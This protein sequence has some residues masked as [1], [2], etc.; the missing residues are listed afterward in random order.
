MDSTLPLWTALITLNSS[1]LLEAS[2]TP[3]SQLKSFQIKPVPS[4]SN[5]FRFDRSL[6]LKKPVSFQSKCLFFSWLPFKSFVLRC[7]SS[8]LINVFFSF[9][10]LFFS[11]FFKQFFFWIRLFLLW[12]H[13]PPF[14]KTALITLN[15]SFPSRTL[16]WDSSGSIKVFL[17]I[18]RPFLIKLLSDITLPFEKGSV[19]FSIKTLV[20]TRW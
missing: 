7:K 4:Q 3:P 18:A 13:S 2:A 9:Y 12:S 1:F 15:S 8:F 19:P 6:P 16:L 5:S 11:S 17:N 20:K 10:Q 14:L